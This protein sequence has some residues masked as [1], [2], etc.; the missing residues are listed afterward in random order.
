MSGPFIAYPRHRDLPVAS[1]D[2][3]LD[4]SDARV[5]AIKALVLSP[6][7]GAGLTLVVRPPAGSEDFFIGMSLIVLCALGWLICH[8][9]ATFQC[10]KAVDIVTAPR[11]DWWWTA[12]FS[13]AAFFFLPVLGALI[14]LA[15]LWHTSGYFR[16]RG[17]RL[18]GLRP[19]EEDLLV[20]WETHRP[21]EEPE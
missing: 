12:P 21:P 13:G 18:R 16:E 15:V 20:W 17:I 11:H 8:A 19:R 1:L 7:V 9:I 3:L 6:I 14:P 10:A 2:E 4:M 5:M